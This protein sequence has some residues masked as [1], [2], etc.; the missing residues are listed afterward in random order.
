MADGG[1][2]Q[3][4]V[5]HEAPDPGSHGIEGRGCCGDLR[6]SVFRQGRRIHVP[7][8]GLGGGG[9]GPHRGGQAPHRPYREC[10]RQDRH[11]HEGDQELGALEGA[12]SRQMA[13]DDQPSAVR[14]LETGKLPPRLRVDRKTHMLR[15]QLGR[16]REAVHVNQ[17]A[18][19]HRRRRRHKRREDRVDLG[20]QL[21][22]EVL[23]NR[24]AS[25]PVQSLSQGNF[26][27][28]PVDAHDAKGEYAD[29]C[30][31]DQVIAVECMNA[32]PKR[33]NNHQPNN[34]DEGRAC[35]EAAWPQWDAAE[36]GHGI[37][38]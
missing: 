16:Q 20:A 9:E 26:G 14:H 35:S 38:A 7:P 4:A 34:E 5:L 30:H 10:R 12:R 31:T 6:R 19:T 17:D 25:D 36:P 29:R 11:D 2:Q 37:S 33:L 3:R 24:Q 27:K 23:R 15:S 1:Q 8:K 32:K 13:G 22:R 28:I 18:V 21:D